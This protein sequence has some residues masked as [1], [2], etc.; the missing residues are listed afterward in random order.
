MFAHWP[1]PLTEDE[2]AYF[3]VDE[4]SEAAAQAKYDL[5]VLGRGLRRDCK[6]DPAKKVRFVVR[7]AGTL[8]TADVEVLKLLLNAEVLEVVPSGWSSD[9]GTPMASNALGELFLPLAG[10][11]DFGAERTRLE[12]ELERVRIEVGKVQDKLENPAFT[13]KVPVKELEEHQARLKEWLGKEA[14]LVVS[15]AELPE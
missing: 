4:T 9:R 12:K 1:R 3:G 7:P 8:A 14:Q 11:I 2:K 10:L 6:I 15:L 5:V 13:S